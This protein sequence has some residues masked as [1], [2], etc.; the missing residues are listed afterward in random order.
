[1]HLKRNRKLKTAL[2]ALQAR[3]TLIALHYKIKI[4]GLDVMWVG[5][6]FQ[7]FK[8]VFL[9]KIKTCYFYVC[10]MHSRMKHDG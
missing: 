9:F 10:T 1:M 7:H 8:Q 2:Q 5:L 4:E 6:V 3:N